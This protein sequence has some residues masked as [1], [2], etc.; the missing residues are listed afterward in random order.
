M[1]ILKARVGGARDARAGLLKSYGEK[2][3]TKP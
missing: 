2:A 1:K 3:T